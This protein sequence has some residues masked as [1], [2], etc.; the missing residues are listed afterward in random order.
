MPTISAA[1]PA[2]LARYARATRDRAAWLEA[3]ARRLEVALARF[4]ARCTEYRVPE[5]DQLSGRLLLATRR[6]DEL[7]SWV[8]GVSAAFQQADTGQLA[9]PNVE[10]APT[11]PARPAQATAVGL[12]PV[13]AAIS[14]YPGNLG[15]AVVMLG[16]QV[17]A[18]GWELVGDE[19]LILAAELTGVA[20]LQRGFAA[21]GAAMGERLRV[22]EGVSAR[23]GPDAAALLIYEAL[24]LRVPTLPGGELI[25]DGRA[26][27]IGWNG[28]AAELLL[29]LGGIEATLTVAGPIWPLAVPALA[30]TLGPALVV[31]GL[32]AVALSVVSDAPHW[33][34]QPIN[35]ADDLPDLVQRSFWNQSFQDT[36]PTLLRL[37]AA[38]VDALNLLLSGTL[39][40]PQSAPPPADEEQGDP[41]GPTVSD[42]YSAIS[43]E[44][45][46]Q[47]VLERLNDDGDYRL[48]ITGLDPSKPGAPNNFEAV[49]ITGYFPPEQNHY[50]QYV[51]QRFFEA[52]RQIPPGSELH[53]Q[54]HSMGGGMALMLRDDPEVRRRLREAGITVPSLTIYGAVV[55]VGTVFEPSL[56][57]GDPFVDTEL[58][59]FVN[60]SDSL[61]LNVGAGYD[62]YAAVQMIGGSVV[63]AP[64]Q[65]HTDYDKAQRYQDLPDDLLGLPYVIEPESYERTVLGLPPAPIEAPPI[66]VAGA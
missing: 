29:L 54:G 11:T 41:L 63:D 7:G 34:F 16:F 21:L 30:T 57:A 22:L 56:P 17:A 9:A 24:W 44:A 48:S 6:L 38:R 42:A 2:E 39:D 61:A 32:G 14:R 26:Q 50:Y 19:A 55:P 51:R 62:G 28:L 58:K 15:M 25:F 46:E 13:Q 35:E 31:C 65:A 36:N 52:I 33:A 5:I 59:A 8:D 20:E 12:L 45:G 49:I 23:S 40:A 18:A 60:T 43:Y 10:L 3:E 27:R 66:R 47:V 53:L 4:S 37:V 1:G 64:A